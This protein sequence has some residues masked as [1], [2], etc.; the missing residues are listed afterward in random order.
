MILVIVEAELRVKVQQT[1]Q[2]EVKCKEMNNIIEL[3][4]VM[5]MDLW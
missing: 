3:V 4:I 2:H 1:T 5:I